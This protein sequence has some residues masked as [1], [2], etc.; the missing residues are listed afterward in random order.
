[1][2]CVHQRS[3]LIIAIVLIFS[4]KFL[5]A[6]QI[7]SKTEMNILSRVSGARRFRTCGV[8]R[9][10]VFRAKCSATVVNGPTGGRQQIV[11]Q[12][13][14]VKDT[15]VTQN[16]KQVIS[17]N[18]AP[19]SFP[20][21]PIRP[22]IQLTAEERDLFEAFRMIVK[23]YKLRTTVRVAGGWVRDRLLGQP[24]KDDVD[25]AL[26][27]LTGKQF[28]SYLVKYD[29]DLSRNV[30][31]ATGAVAGQTKKSFDCM[32]HSAVIKSNPERSKHLE[33]G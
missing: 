2:S 1:M 33:T 15:P 25:I 10:F 7:L 28:M 16:V 23:K 3:L 26:D 21:T 11:S 27:N 12:N 20:Q 8:N 31:N 22:T 14:A 4:P 29:A 5:F 9:V 30:N 17:S 13:A 32:Q 6:L 24:S 19:H 18:Q